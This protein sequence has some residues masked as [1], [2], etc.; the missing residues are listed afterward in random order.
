MSSSTTCGTGVSEI[1]SS[2]L[3][4]SASRNEL[5]HFSKLFCHTRHGNSEKSAP[6]TLQDSVWLE[7]LDTT[8]SCSTTCGTETSTT[9][10]QIP[11]EKRSDLGVLDNSSITCERS[12]FITCTAVRCCC[13]WERAERV[14]ARGSMMICLC[15]D[16]VVVGGGRGALKKNTHDV[17]CNNKVLHATTCCGIATTTYCMQQLVVACVSVRHLASHLRTHPLSL[18]L[19]TPTSSHLTPTHWHTKLSSSS[20]RLHPLST[21]TYTHNTFKPTH[22]HN[23]NRHTHTRNE[24]RNTQHTMQHTHVEHTAQTSPI[25]N[26]TTLL[27]PS[28]P[29][30]PNPPPPPPPDTQH[31]PSSLTPPPPRHPL[32]SPSL[33][34]SHPPCPLPT[35]TICATDDQLH[36]LVVDVVKLFDTVDFSI[37]DCALGRLGLFKWSW[38]AYFSFLGSG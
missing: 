38:R 32:S 21:H 31:H 11:S 23:K 12:I 18:P 26:P 9:C 28:P 22:K 17:A 15:V 16:S 34:P 3:L 20:H 19:L 29:P 33:P 25:R 5:R 27:S 1:C 14:L 35:D 10:S 36:V 37:L 30:L 13:S 2:P 7:I 24:Q 8:K 4:D 6:H